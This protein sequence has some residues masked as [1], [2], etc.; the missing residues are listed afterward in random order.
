[1]ESARLC[2]WGVPAALFFAVVLQVWAEEIEV[3][4]VLDKHDD[5]SLFVSDPHETVTNLPE[6]AFR[7]SE[8]R[9]FLDRLF[10][11]TC[12]LKVYFI[13]ENQNSSVWSEIVFQFLLSGWNSNSWD[14]IHSNYESMH[15]NWG[16]DFFKA[17][18]KSVTQL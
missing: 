1:M 5:A 4:V 2:R 9:K 10:L 6:L 3:L 16:L 18:N 11:T 15:I 17:E 7:Q 13:L 12:K 14:L 8:I